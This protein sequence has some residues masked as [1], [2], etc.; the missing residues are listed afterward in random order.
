MDLYNNVPSLTASYNIKTVNSQIT[1]VVA[2]FSSTYHTKQLNP[3][4]TS[5]A[6][7]VIIYSHLSA[8]PGEMEPFKR[9]PCHSWTSDKPQKQATAKAVWEN[10]ST[11]TWVNC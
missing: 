7:D 10:F 2:I 9:S 1:S 5:P 3:W 8:C 6:S 11:N 4:L